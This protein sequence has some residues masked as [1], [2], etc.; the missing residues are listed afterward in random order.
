MINMYNKII[1]IYTTALSML[2][3]GQYVLIIFYALTSLQNQNT[4]FSIFC[5]IQFCIYYNYRQHRSRGP[6]HLVSYLSQYHMMKSSI[7]CV[8]VVLCS[9]CI[10][11]MLIN[12]FK[13][14][15]CKLNILYLVS[16]SS[17]PGFPELIMSNMHDYCS[18]Q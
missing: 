2:L 12:F 1:Y 6:M 7:L 14:T 3:N 15:I 9:L 17:K 8:I 5:L 18:C 10:L 13:D 16:K 11:I 4:P